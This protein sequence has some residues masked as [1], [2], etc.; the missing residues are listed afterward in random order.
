MKIV[1]TGGPSAGKTSVVEILTRS[2]SHRLRGVPEAASI[3]FRG[4]FPRG[5]GVD[6]LKCQQRAIYHVQRELE[7]LAL[8]QSQGRHVICD[9][10]SLDGIAYWP[11]PESEFLQAVQSTMEEEIKRYDWVIHLESARSHDYQTSDVRIESESQ[12]SVLNER[13]KQAWRLHPNRLII[14]NSSSFLEKVNKAVDLVD[15]ILTGRS[16][17]EIRELLK[18]KHD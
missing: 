9:R 11:G 8:M 3:L 12:A 1:L 14:P 7:N 4:G 15:F 13:V 10:G 6:A 5:A 17:D 2:Q 18:L 16:P